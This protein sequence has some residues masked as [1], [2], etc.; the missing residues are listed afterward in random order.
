MNN[1]F[2]IRNKRYLVTGAASGIGRKCTELLL[3]MKNMVIA[4]DVN[5]EGLDSLEQKYS[6]NLLKPIVADISRKEDRNEIIN[7]TNKK[8]DGLVNCAG[9]IILTP[10]RFVTEKTIK[11][12]DENN[13]EGP[14]LLTSGMIKKKK[15]E[16]GS[17]IIFVSSIMS[18]L[19]TQLNGV[20]TG[21]K[22]AL[23]GI[24]KTFALELA[25]Q[26][27]RV[28]AISPA[29]VETP[30]LEFISQFVNLEE[31]RKDHPLGFGSAIDIVYS[32]IFLLSD[33]SR[34]IT[35]TNLIIDGGYSAQ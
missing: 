27:I 30:M 10:M 34:W 35:G 22:S 31:K 16:Q 17:S 6:G 14:V 3:E 28:N 20:Y 29:F 24:T 4:V 32:I 9:I 12:I 23:A 2:N 26:N 18:I 33:A 13:Y 1:P 25:P 21:T 8:I 5:K 11:K 7:A 19:S 15:I